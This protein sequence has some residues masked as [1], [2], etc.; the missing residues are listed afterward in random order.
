[1]DPVF[2]I[3]A[4]AVP[5]WIASPAP[6]IVSDAKLVALKLPAPTTDLATESV[7]APFT[8]IVLPD[9]VTK[10]PAVAAAVTVA[11]PLK[12]AFP[13]KLQEPFVFVKVLLKIAS[14]PKVTKLVTAEF[15]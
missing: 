15:V 6:P 7:V 12:V 13:L 3:V 2:W 11:L 10:P 4:V 9:A 8:V 14:P 1:M 5:D